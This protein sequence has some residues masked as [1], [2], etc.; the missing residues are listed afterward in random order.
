MGDNAKTPINKHIINTSIAIYVKEKYIPNH[1]VNVVRSACGETDAKA[2]L[3]SKH[4]WI[5][6]QYPTSN[7]NYKLNILRS[8]PTPERKLYL[9]SFTDGLHL[10]TRTSDRR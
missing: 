10:V 6:V 7:G 5:N 2:F 3:M 1:Y 8:N 9:S 4:W